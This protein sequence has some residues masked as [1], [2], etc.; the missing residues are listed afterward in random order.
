MQPSLPDVDSVA[1]AVLYRNVLARL[2]LMRCD[3][4]HVYGGAG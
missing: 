3:R 4:M 1:A 2:R